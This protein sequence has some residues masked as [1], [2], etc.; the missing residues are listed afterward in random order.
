MGRGRVARWGPLLVAALVALPAGLVTSQRQQPIRVFAVP[1]I[2]VPPS[3]DVVVDL[4]GF[5]PP[6]PGSRFVY[7][8]ADGVLGRGTTHDASTSPDCDLCGGA[9]GAVHLL[10]D[11]AP[12]RRPTVDFD[13]HLSPVAVGPLADGAPE[14]RLLAE[15]D[16]SIG[17]RIDLDGDGRGDLARRFEH[18]ACPGAAHRIPGGRSGCD[19]M[20]RAVCD[21]QVRRSAS[22]PSWR[23][24]ERVEHALCLMDGH[25]TDPP[26]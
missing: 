2:V 16:T 3:H 6:A 24:F 22:G 25:L 15:A 9:R 18:R 5:D 23:P 17:W 13:Q 21:S 19:L 12:P 4:L 1:D 7:L 14:P 11:A 8:D 26:F 20:E 10:L